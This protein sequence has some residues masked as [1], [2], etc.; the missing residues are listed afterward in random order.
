VVLVEDDGPSRDLFSAYLE[1]ADLEVA[2]AR[3]GEEGLDSVRRLDPAAVVLDIRLP[4][5]DGWNVLRALK[6]DPATSKVPVV[7]VSI[8]DE[9]A[10]GLALGAAEY[11]VKP[12]GREDLLRALTQVHVLEPATAPDPASSLDKAP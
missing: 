10:K 12:V 1:G 4:R 9:R 5:I 3:D 11:L 6:A 2:V 7:V 8:V